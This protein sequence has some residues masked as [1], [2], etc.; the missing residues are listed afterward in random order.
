VRDVAS[1]AVRPE[2]PSAAPVIRTIA[3]P[4]DTNPAGDIFGG[5]LMVQMNLAAGNVA[6]RRVQGRCATVA[7]D[8]MPS[9]ARS[10][11]ATR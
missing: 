9:T 5:W 3:T 8:A 4:A 11:S 2:Q 7:V 1:A 10:P 6:T